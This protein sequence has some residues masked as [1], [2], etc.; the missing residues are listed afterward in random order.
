M[1]A[2]ERMLNYV[3]VWTTS[4]SS[5]D[6]VPSTSRQFDLAKLL[7]EEMKELGI[8]DA[9]VDDKSYVYGTLAATKGYEDKAKLGF[10]AHLDT[11][12]DISGQ[13]VN[14]QI[15]ENYNGEDI[16]LGDSGRVI[17]VCD[18]P[19]LKSFK[20]RTLITTDGTT[21]LGADDKAGI[22]EIMTVIERIQKENIPHGKICIGFNPDEEIGAG[23]HNF[24]VEK[25]GA[26]FAYTLDGWLEGQIEYEN[27]NASSAT[28]EIKGINVHPGSAKDIMVNSQLLAMEINS[29]L[30]KETPATTEGYEGFYHLMETTGSV[31]YSKLVYIVR[32]HDADKFAAR[33]EFLENIA[34]TMNE[35]YGEGVVTLTIKQQYRNMKEQIEPCMHLI[36]NAK[37]AIK[38]VGL[39]PTVDAIRGGTDGAQLSFKGLPCPNLGTGGA[40]YH[41]ACEHISVEGMDKVVDI[42]VELVKIYAQM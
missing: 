19:H 41:G 29:M 17:R 2:Y 34:R 12:E 16:V 4:D 42:A 30:P 40:A 9:H 20:G 25:F 5:S 3:K 22:A 23:A 21:L 13:N 24:D 7:V 28:F 35:K 31:E 10:I 14:P 11:S 39:E 1:R 33:N 26:D 38:A 15:I 37:K 27:F 8:E 18:F 32:D 6:A 36:D